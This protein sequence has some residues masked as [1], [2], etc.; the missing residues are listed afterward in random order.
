[1]NAYAA[2][3]KAFRAAAPYGST[4]NLTRT[5]NSNVNANNLTENFTI[6]YNPATPATNTYTFNVAEGTTGI[7]AKIKASGV[8]GETGNPVRLS[9]IS[10]SGVRTSAG[11]PVLFALS[12]DRGVAV[13]SPETGTWTAEVSGLNGVAFPEQIKGVVSMLTAAGT[14][15]LSDI[16]GHPAEAAI[17]MAISARLA[18]GLTGGG[19]KPDELLKRIDMADY[20]MMGE[21]IRQFLPIDGSY[22]LTDVKERNLLAESI[23][24]KGGALRDK[25][26]KFNGIM[27]PSA[28]GKF[29]PY[30]KVN[31]A[32]V[33]Y[34]LVQALG[35]QEFA[36]ERN[37]KVPTV[38]V[39]GTSYPIEDAAEIPEGLEGYVSVALELNLINAYFSLTQRPYDLQP[40]LHATFKPLQD[41]T[42]A[43]FAVIITRTHGQWNTGAQPLASSS[44]SNAVTASE[45]NATEERIYSYPNPF[46]NKATISYV[47]PQDGPVQ[48]AVYDVLGKKVKTLV[49]DTMKSGN[50]TVEFDA[51]A[52]PGGTYIYRVEAGNKVYSNRMILTK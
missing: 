45:L 38:E 5:F 50:Y 17:K 7:E 35:L 27:L 1:M 32:E 18:D 23:T 11:I 12:T 9:L 6:N 22:T 13:A 49:A 16:A 26:H 21:G 8:E 42:R 2:V 34:S 10:P 44:T 52:L 4:L 39:D 46:S 3:D 47:V 43:D 41:V 15:G 33:A 51:A 37:G 28:P 19:Y 48:V 30:S 29:S 40:T 24:A 31:R 36:L 14:T 25:E 20:L